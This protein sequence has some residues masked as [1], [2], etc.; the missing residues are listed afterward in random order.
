MI[1]AT[2]AGN[3]IATVTAIGPGGQTR[4]ATASFVR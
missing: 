1:R 4:S 2:L 3:Y